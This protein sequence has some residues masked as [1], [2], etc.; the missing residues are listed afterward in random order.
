MVSEEV[1]AFIL[2]IK[3]GSARAINKGGYWKNNPIFI[4]DTYTNCDKDLFYWNDGW[5]DCNINIGEFRYYATGDDIA[6]M[7]KLKYK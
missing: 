3:D 6:N 1:L 2:I 7:L 4:E 5:S